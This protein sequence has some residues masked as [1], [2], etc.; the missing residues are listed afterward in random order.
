MARRRK[1]IV[2]AIVVVAAAVA[3]QEAGAED[4]ADC[5]PG[6]ATHPESNCWKSPYYGDRHM[7]GGYMLLGWDI[8]HG[9]GWWCNVCSV[10]DRCTEDPPENPPPGDP[11]EE[12][13]G[14]LAAAFHSGQPARLIAAVQALNAEYFVE[15]SSGRLIVLTCSGEVSHQYKLTEQQVALLTGSTEHVVGVDD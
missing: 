1:G 9:G 11:E 10:H 5:L 12:G 2:A 4:C 7:E 15:R 14:G 6:T 3:M 13:D 8:P